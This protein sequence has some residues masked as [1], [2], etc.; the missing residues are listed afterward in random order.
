MS[1]VGSWRRAAWNQGESF[2]VFLCFYQLGA[3]VNRE[4]RVEEQTMQSSF[5]AEM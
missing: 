3:Q 2:L 1:M 4:L 5:A